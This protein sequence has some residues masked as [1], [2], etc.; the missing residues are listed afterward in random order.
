MLTHLQKTQILLSEILS[1]N[2]SYA[3]EMKEELYIF[4]F[5]NEH[6]LHFLNELSTAAA[7]Q[8]KVAV[9]L[10]QMILHEHE[11]TLQEIMEWSV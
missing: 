3:D 10:H 4:L 5:E 1:R 2:G 7:I 9:I 8:N 6:P 11:V